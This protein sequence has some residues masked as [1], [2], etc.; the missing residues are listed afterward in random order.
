VDPALDWVIVA[1][2]GT[3]VGITEIVSRY[4]DEPSR[5]LLN[6]PSLIYLLLNAGAAALALT[7]VRA[8]GWSFGTD[9]DGA[10]RWWQILVAGLGSMAL[11]RSALFNVRV[12]EQDVAVGPSSLLQV[13][14][15]AADRGVDRR[16]ARARSVLVPQLMKDISF[17][18]ASGPL[19]AFCIALLQNLST[20]DQD[21]L[22]SQVAG[23]EAMPMDDDI[24]S[25]L[26][27]LALMNVA[28]E[29]LLKAAVDALHEDIRKD[30]P[31]TNR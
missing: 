7:L 27:G 26:L 24:K 31:P 30:P 18:K 20:E 10:T 28:G 15:N 12:G 14:L 21:K 23:L 22:S 2:L 8:F 17:E 25:L 9:V 5:A 4:R 3:A 11:F 6:L 1:A 19:P 16:R 13:L 29:E